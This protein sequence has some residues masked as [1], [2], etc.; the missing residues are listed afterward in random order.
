ME[1]DLFTDMFRFQQT[2]NTEI[3]IASGG[4][5]DISAHRKMTA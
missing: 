3:N 2:E 5:A 4:I 1:N